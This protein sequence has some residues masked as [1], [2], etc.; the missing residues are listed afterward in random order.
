MSYFLLK[1]EQFQFPSFHCACHQKDGR[2]RVF[3]DSSGD[4]QDS[5]QFKFEEKYLSK[6][7]KFT[8]ENKS[9][10]MFFLIFGRHVGV[11]QLYKFV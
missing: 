11:P 3:F 9:L 4:F 6:L 8:R 5:K 1:V 10:Q 2:D 7:R